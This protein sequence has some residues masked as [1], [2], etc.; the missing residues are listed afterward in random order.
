[1]FIRM[2]RMIAVIAT[3][4]SLC[5]Q[6]D[7]AEARFRR[8]CGW[9][10]YGSWYAPTF[11]GSSC[12]GLEP[13][14]SHY[15][16]SSYT[17]MCHH[18]TLMPI[19]P[20]PPCPPQ[21]APQGLYVE[22]NWGLYYASGKMWL[23]TWHT[24]Q[25]QPFPRYDL[26]VNGINDPCYVHFV[27][28]LPGNTIRLRLSHRP[29]CCGFHRVDY[30]LDGGATWSCLGNFR[31][32]G[33]RIPDNYSHPLL[34]AVQQLSG[35]GYKPVPETTLEQPLDDSL[36]QLVLKLPRHSPIEAEPTSGNFSIDHVVAWPASQSS[37]V[38]ANHLAASLNTGLEMVAPTT[39]IAELPTVL[40]SSVDHVY[41]ASRRRVQVTVLPFTPTVAWQSTLGDP[42]QSEDVPTLLAIRERD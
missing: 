3:G 37:V 13:W 12:C 35:V 27:L 9:G 1:M 39:T 20:C 36:Q 17:S 24:A 32:V 16:P 10:A 30:S 2:I 19:Q 23:T 26:L 40:T 18:C 25:G 15:C 41:R 33:I 14:T 5:G 29:E 22:N 42:A 8:F 21:R 4:V 6:A 34:N 7:Q 31:Y 38:I 11:T 28:Q